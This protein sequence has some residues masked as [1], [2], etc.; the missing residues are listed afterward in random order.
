MS[1]QR[2][3][4]NLDLDSLFPGEALTIG[5]SS[6]VIR[7][8]G[9]EQIAIL[10]KK[11]TGMGSILSGKGVTWENYNSPENLFH[12]GCVLLANFPDVLE[13]ASNVSIDDLKKFPLELI[14]EIVEKVISVNLKSKESLEKNFKSL[15]T[16]FLPKKEDK[17]EPKKKSPEK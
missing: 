12:I 3:S 8:L 9:F 11:L 13:E 10:T 14:V 7:P 17:K 4:L 2:Q 15:A 16:N 1:K 5:N 6:I